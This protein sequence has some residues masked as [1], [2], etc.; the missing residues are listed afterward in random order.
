LLE[1]LYDYNQ[2]SSSGELIL[3]Q[4][5]QNSLL[6]DLAVITLYP[7]LYEM[8][9][10]TRYPHVDFSCYNLDLLSTNMEKPC[11][12]IIEMMDDLFSLVKTICKSGSSNVLNLPS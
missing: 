11:Q 5:G 3:R 6:F 4:P 8:E 9:E 10:I 7:S 1:G 2:K 12:K